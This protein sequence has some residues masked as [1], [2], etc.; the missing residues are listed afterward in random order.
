MICVY[1][2]YSCDVPDTFHASGVVDGVVG[3]VFGVC[4]GVGD[5]PASNASC[6]A[7][8][9]F[10]SG[11]CAALIAEMFPISTVVQ[12]LF[13]SGVTLVG[14]GAVLTCD[15]F[16]DALV[17]PCVQEVFALIVAPH[18]ITEAGFTV[19]D[20]C[21]CTIG[22]CVAGLYFASVVVMSFFA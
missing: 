22:A 1:L 20:I 21:G 12:Y 6:F 14:C 5:L 9:A 2:S 7:C 11:V 19:A 15:I 18:A 10:S 4:V 17:F 8:H 13:I 16:H 3:S